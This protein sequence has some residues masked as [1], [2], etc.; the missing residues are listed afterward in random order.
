MKEMHLRVLNE[1]GFNEGK[2]E[3]FTVW[4]FQNESIRIV[5]NENQQ[6]GCYTVN[7]E[8]LELILGWDQ[9]ENVME[10]ITNL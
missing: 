3:D 6:V 7:G 10:Q 4:R 8:D 2:L 9:I 5:W 1:W